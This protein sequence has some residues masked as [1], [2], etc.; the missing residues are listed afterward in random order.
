MH[1]VLSGE[2]FNWSLHKSPRG[3]GM[4]LTLIYGKVTRMTSDWHPFLHHQSLSSASTT[5]LILAQK[6]SICL[7]STIRTET[8]K[9]KPLYI[10]VAQAVEN[11]PFTPPSIGAL[12][13]GYK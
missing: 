7:P 2:S 6:L 8:F 5:S 13:G 3:C 12:S 11:Q 1:F 9:A 4:D 10:S